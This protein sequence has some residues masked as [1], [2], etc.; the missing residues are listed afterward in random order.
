MG[1][2]LIQG[3][4]PREDVEVYAFDL[5]QEKINKLAQDIDFISCQ[6]LADL[7]EHSDYIVLA[8]KPQVL[9][10]VIEEIKDNLNAEKCLISIAAGIK[11]KKIDQVEQQYLSRSS[12]Y[13]QYSSPCRQGSFCPVL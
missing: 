3:L 4:A 9:K 10:E 11:L 8:V 6:N 7:I 12:G 1:G 5:D 13:A 2:A